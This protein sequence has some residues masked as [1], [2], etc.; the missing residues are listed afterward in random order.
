VFHVVENQPRGSHVGSVSAVDRDATSPRDHQFVY[1]ISS[2]TTSLHRFQVH[3]V[4]GHITTTQRLD[5][6]RQDVYQLTVT[7]AT[8]MT[9]ESTTLQVLTDN[10]QLHHLIF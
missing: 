9:S 2:P 3:P 4:T 1:V 8:N 5:R 7:A 10:N 6:E